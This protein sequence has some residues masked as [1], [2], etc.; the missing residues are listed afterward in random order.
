MH[1]EPFFFYSFDFI[2]QKNIIFPFSAQAIFLVDVS[3]CYVRTFPPFLYSKKWRTCEISRSR[4][5]TSSYLFLRIPDCH[6]FLFNYKK[7]VREISLPTFLCVLCLI[8]NYSQG[9]RKKEERK[10]GKMW[11]SIYGAA[12]KGIFFSFLLF[13]FFNGSHTCASRSNF[14]LSY[15][16]NLVLRPF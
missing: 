1:R 4:R 9:R 16:F 5:D 2:R 3:N 6:F 10:E 14:Y 12:R 8:W 11:F 15:I 13:F 7:K